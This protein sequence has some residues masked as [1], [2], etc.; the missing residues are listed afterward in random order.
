MVYFA[1][2][3]AVYVLV[4]VVTFGI[5]ASRIGTASSNMLNQGVPREEVDQFHADMQGLTIKTAAQTTLVT[6]T[7]IAGI[8]SILVW[9]LG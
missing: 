8:V 7:L 2:F 3:A 1:I 6:G 5:L 4:F 9:A